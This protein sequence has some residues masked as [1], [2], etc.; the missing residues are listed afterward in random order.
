MIKPLWYNNIIAS[1]II[2]PNITFNKY[3][4]H[5]KDVNIKTSIY[6]S[7]SKPT[8]IMEP[9]APYNCDYNFMKLYI[10]QKI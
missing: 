2:L 5:K 8:I 9:N 10:H 7:R 1:N 3:T 6:E 4:F